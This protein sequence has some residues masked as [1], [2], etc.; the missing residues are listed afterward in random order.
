MRCAYPVPGGAFVPGMVDGY[1]WCVACSLRAAAAAGGGGGSCNP[2][3]Y[4]AL[5]D[6]TPAAAG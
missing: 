2:R 3:K 5:G 1:A 4:E 6:V